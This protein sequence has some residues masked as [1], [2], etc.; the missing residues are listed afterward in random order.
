[1]NTY[2]LID[3][4]STFTKVTAVDADSCTILGTAQHWT[5]VDR[6]INDGL[7]H[8]MALLEQQT[9]PVHYRKKLA[10]SSAAGG[11][12]MVTSGL[13]PDLTVQAAQQA[14]LGA[15]AK[16]T[17]VYSQ[18]LMPEDVAQ[19]AADQPDIILLTGGTDGGNSQC[20]L[21]NAR[22]LAAHADCFSRKLPVILAGNRV[23]AAQCRKILETAFEVHVCENVMPALGK[24]H[25][26][27]VQNQIRQIFLEQIIHA[28][29]IAKA[30]SMIDGVIMPTPAAVLQ[31]LTLL[32]KGTETQPGLG[33][34]MA[35]DPGGATTDVY[36]IADG[37]PSGPNT[38]LASALPEPH[39][40]RTVE[41][42]I[43]MRYSIHGIVEN[44]G[45]A[46][47]A[48]TAGVSVPELTKIVQQLSRDTSQ[49]P[50]DEQHRNVDFALASWACWI[51]LKR[52]CGT[53]EPVWTPA[54]LAL[55]QRGKD[56][57]QVR[58]LIVTG[59]ALIR[60][61]Q[62]REILNTALTLQNDTASLCPTQPQI[63]IDRSYILSAMGLLSEADPDAALSIM[64]K[65]LL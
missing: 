30:G 23:C 59:G 7:A 64:K 20:I 4:G 36:S 1:M 11:L 47:V 52:H 26:E 28:K 61:G 13:V 45:A 21:A 2:L 18:Y 40:K 42:D 49:L 3:F 53:I 5:T 34:L 60:S 55:L 43:G 17:S 12:R 14:S 25:T 19:M 10:C 48:K 31:A 22:T 32:S 29:G 35:I 65:E 15:G 57:R 33:D 50:Q 37:L 27:P 58:H 56:L 9:G 54:G 46:A 6:D 38:T 51:A 62:G 63:L 39:S 8:A 24:L 16:V 41:G 44:A